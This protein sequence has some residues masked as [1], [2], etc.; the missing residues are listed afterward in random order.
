MKRPYQKSPL[1]HEEQTARLRD[2]GMQ[3]SDEKT[4]Q[5]YLQHINYYRLR[6][7]WL[8][9]EADPETHQFRE[10]TEFD[11]VLNRYIFDRELR[12]L[13]LDAIERIEVSIRA[14]WSY[15]FSHAEGPHGYL[16]AEIKTARRR[17]RRSKNIERLKTEV[18]QS[19]ETFITHFRDNYA[20]ELPPIWA[21]SE[22][23][24]L[25]SL[26][27]WFRDLTPPP[28]KRN[29]SKCY[30]L[31]SDVLDSWL[32]HLT[33]VRNLCAHHSRV[34][35]RELTITPMSPQKK[36]ARLVEE[37][38]KESRKVYNTIL[39]L[40]YFMDMIAPQHTWRKRLISLIQTHNI[41]THSMGFIR[42]W[43]TRTIWT[44]PPAPLVEEL[45]G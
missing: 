25:G 37:F 22:I 20:E 40:L 29:I 41:P 2:R 44:P 19:S 8:S 35:N 6:A 7:Y 4:A 24:S 15:H 45:K 1:A 18:N 31:H 42:G 21:V 13:L 43:N 10:G 28:I 9:F 17:A 27:R 36:P 5:F 16:N 38:Q 23:M 33:H 32:Q 39:I 3:F 14:Q 12:L 30:N 34:W 26:S 11:E